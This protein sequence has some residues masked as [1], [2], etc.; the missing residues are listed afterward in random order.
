MKSS[1][2]AESALSMKLRRTQDKKRRHAQTLLVVGVLR[3]LVEEPFESTL[4]EL[5]LRKNYVAAK[6]PLISVANFW[7]SDKFSRAFP[8]QIVFI[9]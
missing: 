2:S 3:E 6:A 9:E 8:C 1:S 5:E 4:L 7:E